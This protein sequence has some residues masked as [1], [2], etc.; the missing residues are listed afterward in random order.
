[1]PTQ[2]Y[3][4]AID[5]LPYL[6]KTAHWF[7]KEIKFGDK[8]EE[9]L[10]LQRCLK[11]VGLFNGEVTGYYGPITQSAVMDFQVRFNVATLAE[12]F[13]PYL[14]GKRCGKKTLAKLNQLFNN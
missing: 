14:R 13:L 11:D 3:K 2:N 12:L 10:F 4:G 8:G 5:P 9:V 1:M 7:S 6:E